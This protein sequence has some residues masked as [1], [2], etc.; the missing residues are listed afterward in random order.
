MGTFAQKPQ[1]SSKTVSV[2]PA[3]SYWAQVNRSRAANPIHHRQR[4][5]GNQAALRQLESTRES[6][7]PEMIARPTGPTVAALPTS[8][9]MAGAAQDEGQDWPPMAGDGNGVD[10]GGTL[11][12][13]QATEL[14][15]CVRIMGDEAYC[16][17]TVLGEAPEPAASQPILHK[18]TVSGPI[19][20]DC[21]GFKWIVQWKLDKPTTKGGWVV[22]KVESPY[23]V[24]DCGDKAVDPTKVG[25]WQPS[26]CPYW[27]AWQINKGQQVTT[28]AEGG[29]LEDDTYAAPSLGSDTEGSVT[30]KGTAEFYEGLTL[31]SSF[32]VTNKA[33]AWILPTTKSAPK[34]SGG[35]GSIS[36]N[37]KASWDCCSK[38]KA[39]TKTTK[40]E[41]V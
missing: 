28:Y 21:G 29:D 31:P 23:D 14:V 39:A 38:E 9:K 18:T 6:V 25:G 32:T 40:I 17:Q 15:E 34:L 24:K 19:S 11:P 30:V 3:T 7:A 16:R 2:K 4:A 12:Y 1:A 33:P 35:T 5:M 26:W 10:R 41:T 8:G 37:L 22:Q 27:E 36:H 13:R 20:S